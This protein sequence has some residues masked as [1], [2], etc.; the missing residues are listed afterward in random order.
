MRKT[1]IVSIAAFVFVLAAFPL[2]IIDVLPGLSQTVAYAES[3][4]VAG[5][6]TSIA[7]SSV[8]VS[9][10]TSQVV[11]TA[12]L[13][14]N[15]SHSLGGGMLNFY[16]IYVSPDSGVTPVTASLGSASS[17]TTAVLTVARPIKSGYVQYQATLGSL[18]SNLVTISAQ[19]GA[20]KINFGVINTIDGHT[21]S[22]SSYTFPAYSST[23][24]LF[25]KSSKPFLANTTSTSLR[26]YVVDDT[27][28]NILTSTRVPIAAGSGSAQSVSF[29]Q[30]YI[31]Y[32]HTY[33][34][35]V[36]Y[37]LNSSPTKL[38]DLKGIQYASNTATIKRKAWPVDVAAN[39]AMFSASSIASEWASL[40]QVT[41]LL[42]EKEA[43]Q[44]IGNLEG[45]PYSVRD[46]ANRNF[47]SD[48]EAEVHTQLASESV[49]R[50]VKDELS[51]RFGMLQQIGDA[52]KDGPSG[53]K[54]FLISL[55]VVGDGRAAIAVGD[56]ST[57]DYV[58]YLIPGM[59]SNVDVQIQGLTGG[60]DSI[61]TAQQLWL[62]KLNPNI[63]T[64]HLPKVATLAWIGYQT[65]N[66]VNVASLS[67]A[68]E[69]QQSL[70]ASIKGLRAERSARLVRHKNGTVTVGKQP[71]VAILAHSY[72]TTVAMLSLQDDQVSVNAL[73]IVG[74]PGSPA[75][76]A[77]KLNVTND[78]VW[79]GASSTD[80]VAQTG[81]FGSQPALASYGAHHFGVDGAVD[82]VTGKLMYPVVGHDGY[83]VN[84]TESL[85]NMVLIGMGRNDLALGLDG[86][87]I[88]P[89]PRA[90]ATVQKK[91]QV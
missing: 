43:P 6:P 73:A 63:P 76:T 38:S 3:G 23:P 88:P 71:F 32:S 74:S 67:L 70:S 10:S 49:G 18:T 7:L 4:T 78:N 54:R 16:Q 21:T 22:V 35:Y 83:F 64:T 26:V 27:T 52:L 89:A 81:I 13:D 66:I 62:K 42:M 31:L 12:T 87:M 5:P 14:S 29:S 40:P 57:A 37:Y 20:I 45:I 65:P 51:K 55:D 39:T 72:G 2:S 90:H 33:Q 60:A 56:L 82:P 25:W 41:K 84:G 85:R 30:F 53:N 8:P 50:G 79:V 34:A 77:G 15:I 24:Q 59:F 19:T 46:I 86:H 58:D 36:A 9:G 11:L 17:G 48:S 1:V 28:G 61:V 69:G 68:K 80:P 47:L 91:P 44:L 75:Q